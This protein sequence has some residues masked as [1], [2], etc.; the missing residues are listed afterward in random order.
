VTEKKWEAT[1]EA[2]DGEIFVVAD[3]LRVAKRGRPGTEHAGKWIPLEPG[4]R[5]QQCRSLCPD[6]RKKRRGDAITDGATTP[7]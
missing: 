7:L 5:N 6:D 4:Y 3:G 2:I 1:I